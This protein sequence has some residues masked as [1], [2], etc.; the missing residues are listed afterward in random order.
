MMNRGFLRAGRTQLC[1]VKRSGRPSIP[2]ACHHG[3]TPS[4]IPYG[5]RRSPRRSLGLV[6]FVPAGSRMI[7]WLSVHHPYPQTG[8][9]AVCFRLLAPLFSCG[10]RAFTRAEFVQSCLWDQEKLANPMLVAGPA[11]NPI[12]EKERLRRRPRSASS[13]NWW[14]YPCPICLQYPI[15]SAWIPRAALVA[16]CA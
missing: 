14:I 9:R 1:S 10:T 8:E 11:S 2:S 13:H 4:P 16:G 6:R 7:W 3:K 5:S 15:G 12:W